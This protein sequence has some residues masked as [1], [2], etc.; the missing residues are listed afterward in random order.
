MSYIDNSEGTKMEINTIAT[1]KEMSYTKESGIIRCA[2]VLLFHV[3]KV[4][5]PFRCEAM[6]RKLYLLAG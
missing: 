2:F 1:L 4:A 5:K 6:M 3:G